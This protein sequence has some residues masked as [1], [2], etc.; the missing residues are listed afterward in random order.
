MTEPMQTMAPCDVCGT[1]PALISI[2]LLT[3]WTQRKCCP[4]C[5]PAFLRGTADD[6][7]QTFAQAASETGTGQQPDDGARLEEGTCPACG[8]A[9]T[10]HY[11]I[12]GNE[13]KCSHDGCGCVVALVI[14]QPPQPQPRKR[15]PRKQAAG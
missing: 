10:G 13:I 7:E 8:H 14:E 6:I 5:A 11:E 3:D 4:L 2:M 1:N 9:V 12:P 15:A